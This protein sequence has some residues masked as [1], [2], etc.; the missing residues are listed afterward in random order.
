MV[1][2]SDTQQDF[3]LS[4]YNSSTLP[5]VLE[6]TTSERMKINNR[7]IYP[8]AHNVY[9]KGTSSNASSYNIRIS[10]RGTNSDYH[11][12]KLYLSRHWLK[13]TPE[14]T[15]SDITAYTATVTLSCAYGTEYVKLI[16]NGYERGRYTS[17]SY[18]QEKTTSDLGEVS[19]SAVPILR[20]QW[21]SMVLRQRGRYN[22]ATNL[23]HEAKHT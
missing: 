7:V 8:K 19:Y 5:S 15:F 20:G 3:T 12:S 23:I 21:V 4:M 10:P 14:I 18:T 2:I 6:I 16:V 22:I 17:E 11:Y 9:A 1:L 13:Q